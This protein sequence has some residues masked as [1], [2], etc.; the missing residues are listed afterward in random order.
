M[1]SREEWENFYERE[2]VPTEPSNFCQFIMGQNIKARSVIDLGCGNCRD[3]VELA[4]RYI[5][6]AVDSACPAPDNNVIKIMRCDWKDAKDIIRQTDIVY[7]RFFL[8]SIS[9]EEIIELMIM[10]PRYF[11][12]EFRIEG[13]RP[14]LYQDHDRNLISWPWI[15][16]LTKDLCYN[17]IVAKYGRGMA[18]YG[19]EDPLVG[20][21]ILKKTI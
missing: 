11:C 6:T 16:Q 20:R 15:I 17:V 10:T 8:H 13:D 7:S 1:R 12:A 18:K 21:I 2:I 4:K 3:S 19:G 5:T 14:I 9:N